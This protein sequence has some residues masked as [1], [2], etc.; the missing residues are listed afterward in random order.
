MII[1]IHLVCHYI[2]VLSPL[3]LTLSL[4]YTPQSDLCS[5]CVYSLFELNIIII[6]MID[7]VVRQQRLH[8][9]ITNL[10]IIP[11]KL[12]FSFFIGFYCCC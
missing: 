4:Y 5:F 3:S 9:I 1:L 10:I 8:N 7:K 11:L 12:Y 2:I 6:I